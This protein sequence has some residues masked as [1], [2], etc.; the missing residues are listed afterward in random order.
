MSL[1]ARIVAA[2]RAAMADRVQSPADLED[3]P[4]KDELEDTSTNGTLRALAFHV[5]TIEVVVVMCLIAL[6]KGVRWGILRNTGRRFCATCGAH[7][8]EPCG[9]PPEA[10]DCPA[11][12]S[13][14]PAKAN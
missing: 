4:T 1:F 13:R 6:P 3:M 10:C 8:V 11:C 5:E 12:A 9:C 14:D 2:G 7:G